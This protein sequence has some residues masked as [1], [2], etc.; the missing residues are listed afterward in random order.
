MSRHPP[1]TRVA[2]MWSDSDDAATEPSAGQLPEPSEEAQHF[3]NT[4]SLCDF[5][6]PR[7]ASPTT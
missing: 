2:D 3:V 5:L 7:V 4:G 1:G 6:A